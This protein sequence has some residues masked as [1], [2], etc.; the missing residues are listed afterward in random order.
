MESK[1][2]GK[3]LWQPVLILTVATTTSS[4]AKIGRAATSLQTTRFRLLVK[5]MTSNQSLRSM[6]LVQ[7]VITQIWTPSARWLVVTV[8]KIILSIYQLT[9]RKGS[10]SPSPFYG[11]YLDVLRLIKCCLTT[12]PSL[13][14]L[15]SQGHQEKSKSKLH[16]KNQLRCKFQTH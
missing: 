11:K 5:K 9:D 4:P 12:T 3:A 16:Q 15:Y 8:A 13:L 14:S 1:I 7:L 2:G 6:L 10:F